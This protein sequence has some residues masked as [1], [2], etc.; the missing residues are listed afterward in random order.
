M[1][2]TNDPRGSTWLAGL[3]LGFVCG[4][5]LLE[6]FLGIL[7]LAASLGLI[8]W[9]GPRLLAGAGLLTGLGLVWA[10]LFTNVAINCA[11]PQ[12]GAIALRRGRP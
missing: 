12:P 11:F 6:G 3:V 5:L 8:A 4:L 9:K 10:V 7:F 2:S 1:R